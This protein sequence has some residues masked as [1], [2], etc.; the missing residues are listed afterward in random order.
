MKVFILI[1]SLVF[2]GACLWALYKLLINSY[3]L[4]TK[5]KHVTFEHLGQ[6]SLES[7]F[8]RRWNNA[9]DMGDAVQMSKLLKEY[10]DNCS[11]ANSYCL[12]EVYCPECPYC[13]LEVISVVKD[14]Q[15]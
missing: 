13:G 4:S 3:F 12:T 11:H 6:V 10:R 1:F 15:V 9:R 14:V 2:L 8:M 7:D 5:Q